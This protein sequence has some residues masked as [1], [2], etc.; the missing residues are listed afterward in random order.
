MN[1][2]VYMFAGMAEIAAQKRHNSL[3]HYESRDPEG[4]AILMKPTAM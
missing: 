2:P 1:A 3:N 4:G